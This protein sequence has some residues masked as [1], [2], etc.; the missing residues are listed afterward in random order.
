MRRK[1]K[2]NVLADPDPVEIEMNWTDTRASFHTNAFSD[3]KHTAIKQDLHFFL[4]R[5]PYLDCDID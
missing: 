5:S 4:L 2:R 3:L 1:K